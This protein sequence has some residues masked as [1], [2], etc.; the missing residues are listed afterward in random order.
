MYPRFSS[1]YFKRTAA[2]LENINPN[3][4]DNYKKIIH[5]L[6]TREKWITEE[7]K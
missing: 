5:I 3:S 6:R 7:E 4:R 2:H 1:L